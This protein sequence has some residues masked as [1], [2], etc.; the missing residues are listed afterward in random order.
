MPVAELECVWQRLRLLAIQQ[1]GTDLIGD[2]RA[3]ADQP[4]THP[5]QH[6]QSS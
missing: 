2:A 3:L 4:L 6:L 5:V 1:E